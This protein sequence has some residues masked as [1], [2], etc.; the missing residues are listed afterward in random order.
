[1]FQNRIYA[2]LCTTIQ[3]TQGP[4]Y[5]LLSMELEQREIQMHYFQFC[6]PH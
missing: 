4:I 2:A 3:H 5:A 6:V 1:M